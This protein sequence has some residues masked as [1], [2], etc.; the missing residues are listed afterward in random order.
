VNPRVVSKLN[1]I[2]FCRR[3]TS[4]DAPVCVPR[5]VFAEMKLEELLSI[6]DSQN[7]DNL[8]Y[9]N[10][11]HSA[12]LPSRAASYIRETDQDGDPADETGCPL[13]HYPRRILRGRPGIIPLLP[14]SFQGGTGND[15][16]LVVAL[17]P[18]RIRGLINR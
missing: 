7:V 17:G 16:L 18:V 8:P 2:D 15:P 5:I 6:P 3:L 11:E 14:A 4:P 1:P 10:L 9:L 13:P 12:R